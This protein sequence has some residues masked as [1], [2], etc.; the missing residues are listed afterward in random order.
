[1]LKPAKSRL[2][3]TIVGLGWCIAMVLQ[4]LASPP[5]GEGAGTAGSLDLRDV[6]SSEESGKASVMVGSLSIMLVEFSGYKEVRIDHPFRAGDRFRFAVSSNGGGWLYILHRSPTG[7][8]QQLWPQ[9]DAQ[10]GFAPHLEV[11][12]GQTYLIPPSPGVFIFDEEVGQEEFIVAIRSRKKAPDLSLLEAV[13]PSASPGIGKETL[14][15]AQPQDTI[16]ISS[17]PRK[18]TIG[19]IAI[20]GDPFGGG[21]TRGIFFDPGTDD[22]DPRLYFSAALDDTATSAIVKFKL[23]HRE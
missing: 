12:A 8:A 21:T 9:K 20:R 18:K 22:P 2:A 5:E 16:E 3:A 14:A 1:M 11:K 13:A 4:A 23:R 17:R 15:G 19:N 7:K 10:T 6:Y